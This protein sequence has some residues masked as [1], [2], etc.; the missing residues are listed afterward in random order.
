M[1]DL[2][3]GPSVFPGT[4]LLMMHAGIYLLLPRYFPRFCW[5]TLLPMKTHIHA[6]PEKS[7][8]KPIIATSFTIFI[9][10]H[11]HSDR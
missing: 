10:N 8:M 5:G 4:W 11:I 7:M 3:L 2:L 9:D 1:D 6:C